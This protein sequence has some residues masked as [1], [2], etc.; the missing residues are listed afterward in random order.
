ML[1]SEES[2]VLLWKRRHD[3]AGG[4]ATALKNLHLQQSQYG[5]R[6]GLFKKKI[7]EQYTVMY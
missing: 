2:E 3:R 4:L 1:F 5:V 6:L 7:R